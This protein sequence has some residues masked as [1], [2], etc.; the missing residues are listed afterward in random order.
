M[1][2][3]PLLLLAAILLTVLIIAALL[4][5]WVGLLRELS[6]VSAP[7][8]QGAANSDNAR[9]QTTANVT[10]TVASRGFAR[11]VLPTSPDPAADQPV[12]RAQT[13]PSVFPAPSGSE[14]R[15]VT[16]QG[17]GVDMAAASAVTTPGPSVPTDAQLAALRW[18][19]SRGQYGINTGNGYYGA[20]Q[21]NLET[22]LGIGMAGR[23]DLASRAVQDAAVR[24]LFARR[25]WQPWPA[26]SKALG[27]R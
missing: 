5:C 7:I 24:K 13:S 16:T 3:R 17:P 19:E 9:S 1:T 14:R 18:C 21:F 4:W 2:R 23:P 15:S 12:A 27:L 6:Q 22:W 26:C 10:P 20:Y 8:G 11:P 25:G